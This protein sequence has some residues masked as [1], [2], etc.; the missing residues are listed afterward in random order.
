[1]TATQ[2]K[3]P[4][5]GRLIHHYEM[6]QLDDTDRDRF[7]DHLLDCDYCADEVERMEPVAVGL[8]ANRELIRKGLA[9]EGITFDALKADLLNEAEPIQRAAA[10]RRDSWFARMGEAFRQPMIRWTAIGAGTA[11]T[12]L[13]VILLV[14]MAPKQEASRRYMPMLTFQA[15]PYEGS[16]VLRGEGAADGQKDF[17]AG[18]QAYLQAD[19]KQ[20]M[21]LIGK[22]VE[23]SPDRAEWWLYLGVCGYLQRDPGPTIK[24]L[25]QADGIAQGG[26]KLRTRWFLAQ[27]YL[28]AGDRESAEPM[29]EWVIAQEQDYSKEAFNI[30]NRL[31]NSGSSGQTGENRLRLL[32]PAGGEVFLVG[33]MINVYW[34]DD[35]SD[36][37]KQYQVWLSTDGGVT[38]PRLLASGISNLASEWN[39][40][41]ADVVGDRLFLRVH[42]VREETQAQTVISKPFC[43]T[44]PPILTILNP[45]GGAHWRLGLSYE[46]AWS[47]VGTLP[48]NYSLG[49][50]K[51]AAAET[52]LV[53]MLAS[54]LPKTTL[55][56]VWKDSSESSEEIEPGSGYCV[57]V[58]GAFTE[59]EVASWSPATLS[60]A[61]RASLSVD[62]IGDVASEWHQG[63]AIPI[64]WSC[65]PDSALGYTIELCANQTM[66]VRPLQSGLSRTETSWNWRNAGPP[67]SYLVR[68]VAHY[69]EGDLT[70]YSPARLVIQPQ[71][72]DNSA[73]GHPA[74][75][76]TSND[77]KASL[78]QNYPNPFNA[79]TTISF[80][81]KD[82]GPAKL[83]IYNSLGQLVSRPI[84]GVMGSGHHTVQFDGRQLASGIYI[85]RL[86]AHGQVSQQRM[87]LTK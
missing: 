33:S 44:V 9:A 23:K 63:D 67:G 40:T 72:A 54:E 28:L 86:E 77:V 6:G 61:P 5:I 26:V 65:Q 71:T 18:M 17:D 13:A 80:D 66:T 16:L 48:I 34:S 36:L 37:A 76:S 69:S 21:R 51:V 52:S 56:W 22:A 39:W 73:A 38:F 64:S 68:V 45:P 2:C 81:L 42:A 14:V 43:I 79:V 60:I 62:P 85:C 50:Y 20:A 59:S 1:M 41:N 11:V 57:R 87:T 78:S 31:R 30:L 58:T 19:Y 84:D 15:L 32:S 75:G 74:A 24:A 49:L 55:R 27:A 29:L 3:N 25:R 83:S 7:E 46:I 4:D 82:A 35:S 70:A 12:A 53:R 10:P 47:S 8:R